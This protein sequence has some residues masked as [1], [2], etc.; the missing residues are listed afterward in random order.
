MMESSAD[1]QRLPAEG[2][3]RRGKGWVLIATSTLVSRHNRGFSIH[4]LPLNVTRRSHCP[5]QH[6]VTGMV[7]LLMRRDKTLKICANHY[8]SPLMDL[9]PHQGSNKTWVYTCPADFADGE[10]TTE[11]FAV[12]FGD[13]ESMLLC[14]CALQVLQTS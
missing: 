9:Q 8:L 14:P 10:V 5:L 7:R 4:S 13:A 6:K 3:E 12:R 11:V 2:L 1:T